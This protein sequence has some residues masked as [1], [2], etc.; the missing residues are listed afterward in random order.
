[1]KKILILATVFSFFIFHF[2]CSQ[3]QAPADETHLSAYARLFGQEL[4]AMDGKVG[5]GD[6][7]FIGR[8]SLERHCCTYYVPAIIT[9]RQQPLS[10]RDC[11]RYGVKLQSTSGERMATALL[12]V[13]KYRR[14]VSSGCLESIEI[15]PPVTPRRPSM[16]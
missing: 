4:D 10:K 1:M 11:R 5:K 8:Y 16:R 6:T 13:R 2:S 7:A 15:T 12:S 9:L 14:L 3:A